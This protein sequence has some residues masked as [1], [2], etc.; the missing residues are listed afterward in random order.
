MTKN[1]N[2]VF[3]ALSCGGMRG[4]VQFSC[5]HMGIDGTIIHTNPKSRIFGVCEGGG[6]GGRAGVQCTERGRQ[7]I[8]S[9]NSHK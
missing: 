7:G 5:G 1:P 4:R 8:Q 2:L 3:F 6:G 9:N